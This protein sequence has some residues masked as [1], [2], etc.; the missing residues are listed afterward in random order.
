MAITGAGGFIGRHLTRE[1]RDRG[2]RVI[3]VVRPGSPV[4]EADGVIEHDLGDVDV[5]A[6]QL[7]AAGVSAVCHLAWV[8]HPRS[9]GMDYD[10]Q[11]VGDVVPSA[12]LG[13]AAGLAGVAHVVFVSSGGAV[14]VAREGPRPAYGWAKLAVEALFAATSR[15]FGYA[16]TILRPTALIGPGQDPTR[17]LGAVTIFARQILLGEPIR[18]IGSPATSR[19]FL[20]VADL[21][22]CIGLV[23]ERRVAG[24]FELGGP[25]V[26]RL[27]ALVALLERSLGRRAQVEVVDGT[28]IDPT[29]VKLDNTAIN[30]AIGWTPRRTLA[31]S[32]PEIV[33]D[34][35]TRLGVTT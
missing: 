33:A 10:T 30:D 34:L 25:D 19:D 31:A 29:I 24:V 21:S 16:L 28:G 3:A 13:V 9:A 4:G 27:D 26:V 7:R 15:E 11:I 14:A 5:L 32:L 8:G 20:H 1:L 6:T 18:I 23:I 2:D 22:E 35:A 12:N 17:G